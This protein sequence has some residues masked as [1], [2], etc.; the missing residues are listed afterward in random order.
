MSERISVFDDVSISI[1]TNL[2]IYIE[3]EFRASDFP[4]ADRKIV[5]FNS[6]LYAAVNY[7]IANALFRPVEEVGKVD[8][9]LSEVSRWNIAIT[10]AQ[11]G[12]WEAMSEELQ[13]EANQLITGAATCKDV[14]LGYA[15]S[16]MATRLNN[17]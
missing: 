15:L 13:K 14:E 4:C 11:Y 9:H 1:F 10:F 5:E 12:K 3:D 6:M 16:E 17:P 2:K 8:R 7:E